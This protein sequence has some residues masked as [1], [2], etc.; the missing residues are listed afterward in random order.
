MA[1]HI[2]LGMGIVL[3]AGL[4]LFQVRSWRTGDVQITSRQK[5]MR[6]ACACVMILIML[7][8]FVG[9]N[10]LTNPIARMEYWTGCFGLGFLLMLL[11]L[12]DMRETGIRYRKMRSDLVKETLKSE[13]DEDGE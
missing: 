5:W 8:E 13:V 10:W 9:D 3:I 7:M 6:I 11:A 4:L 2:L 12:L 1:M